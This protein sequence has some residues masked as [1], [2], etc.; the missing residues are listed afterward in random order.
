MMLTLML[1]IMVTWTLKMMLT[2]ML[3]DYVDLNVVNDVDLD[4]EE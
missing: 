3:N 4:I 1:K 2:R